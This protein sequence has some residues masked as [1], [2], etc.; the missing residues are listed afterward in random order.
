M[1][2]SFA[3][4]NFR[5]IR[6]RVKL[7]LNKSA[8]KGLSQNYFKSAGKKQLLK[9]AVIYGANASGKSGM[10]GALHALEFLVKASSG[11]KPDRKINPYEP[12]MLE[13]SWATNPVVFEIEFAVGKYSYEF[14]VAFSEKK[15]EEEELYFS[16]N[17]TRTLLYSR[18]AGSEVK[19]GDAYRGP[20][21]NLEKLLLP[22]QLLLS[23]AAENNVDVLLAPYRFFSEMLMVYP[24]IGDYQEQDLTRLYAQRLAE[25]DSVFSRRFNALICA[26]DTG[27][28]SVSAEAV[29]WEKMEFPG[30]IPDEIQERVREKYKYDIKTRHVLY[31]GIRNEGFEKFDVD[32]E[33]QGTKSLFVIGGIILDALE[34]GRALIVDEFEKN[35]HPNITK[36][37]INLFHNELTNSKNAQLVFATHDITQLSNENFRRDQVWFTEKNEFGATLL[38]RC[39]D[40]QG[41]RLNTPLD[42]WYQSG[43]FGATPIID[44]VD[45]LISM[46]PA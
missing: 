3:V 26:L 8:L 19:F 35:L 38:Y 31:D 22:N 4:T 17:G 12:H 36:Y 6:E 15:I 16:P 46:Q 45:F 18:I 37:L 29:N 9:S 13:K 11:F 33:S 21:K 41:I 20:K 23:K 5:S 2:V 1:L 44:D 24:F 7:D 14:K 39:A 28:S 43:R 32:Q 30:N 25:G 10:L 42:K 40:I 27:I 34:T